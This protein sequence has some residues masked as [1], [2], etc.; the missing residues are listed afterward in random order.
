MLLDQR[1]Q[2]V[3]AIPTDIAFFDADQGETFLEQGASW[4][5]VLMGRNLR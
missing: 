5:D 3:G 1:V 4:V 2:R